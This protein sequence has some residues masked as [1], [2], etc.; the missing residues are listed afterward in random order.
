MSVQHSVQQKKTVKRFHNTQLTDVMNFPADEKAM[1]E[2]LKKR[3]II[4]CPVQGTVPNSNPPISFYRINIGIRNQ[5]NS[6]GDLILSFDRS[7]S[8]GVSE[9]KNPESGVLQG[10]SMSISM[11]DRDGATERQ[12]RTVK[13]IELLSE[14]LIEHITTDDIKGAMDKWDLEPALLKKLNPLYIKK[15]KGKPVPGA[16]PAF[17]PKLIWFK[18]GKDKNGKDKPSRMDTIFYHEDEIDDNGE[19]VMVE[20]LDYVGKRCYV[21]PAVKFEGVFIGSKNTLQCK[22]Y[23]T[24]IKEADTG[25]KKLLQVGVNRAPTIVI[26]SNPLLK[27]TTTEEYDFDTDTDNLLNSESN[28]KDVSMTSDEL[29]VSDDE[30]KPKKKTVT[31]KVKVSAKNK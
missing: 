31:K 23:E 15:E 29:Y 13:F 16:S 24:L 2:E 7:F 19:P 20:A 9:N 8:F 3:L 1:K 5:D 25:R 4:D 21:T 14:V 6:E 30:D 17:Y 28:D 12:L 22:I 11:Y 18:G 26:G 27:K 10:Y